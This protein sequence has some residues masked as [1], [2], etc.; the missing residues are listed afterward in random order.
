[1]AKATYW[2]KGQSIDYTNP[3]EA[4]ISAGDVI[5][6]GTRIGIAGTDIPAGGTGSVATEGVFVFPTSG[7][8][9]TLGASVYWD[10]ASGVIT[11]TSGDNTVPAGWCVEA[12]T[13][14][15][16]SVKVKLLG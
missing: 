6:L 4:K 9:I 10:K 15:A 3:S 12:C 7:N 5:P 2:Q 14:S 13:A 11:A 1:M 16:A 8:E